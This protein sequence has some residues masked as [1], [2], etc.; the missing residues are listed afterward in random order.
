M[1][2]PV[3][4]RYEQAKITTLVAETGL[5]FH[6]GLKYNPETL[7]FEWVSGD[8]F[9]YSHWA[10][11][12]PGIGKKMVLAGTLK[13]QSHKIFHPICLLKRLRGHV[14]MSR[15]R[16][17]SHTGFSMFIRGPDINLLFVSKILLHCPLNRLESCYVLATYPVNHY[18]FINIRT[19]IFL[20]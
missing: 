7:S 3:V 16:K 11:Y 17:Q 9:T 12:E 2:F 19:P 6:V 18:F 8:G 10:E 13:G 4:C 15:K 5:H 14:I 1:I 20:N